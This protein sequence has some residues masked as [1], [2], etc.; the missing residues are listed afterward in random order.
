MPKGILKLLSYA[1]GDFVKK[2]KIIPSSIVKL[3]GISCCSWMAWTSI[4]AYSEQITIDSNIL[5]TFESVNRNKK[6]PLEIVFNKDFIDF[7]TPNK[8]T[9][10]T[11]STIV[12]Q[13]PLTF[14]G[15]Q[16]T[17]RFGTTDLHKS[18]F[19]IEMDER[20]D[21]CI[22]KNIGS[23]EG[24][25]NLTKG[26]F[27]VPVGTIKGVI[28]NNGELVL[29][30][31]NGQVVDERVKGS[32]S[33]KIQG[34]GTIKLQTAEPITGGVIFNGE[35]SKSASLVVNTTTAPQGYL[36]V[37][38]EKDWI[39]FDQDF[40]GTYAGTLSGE[41]GLAKMG[42]GALTLIGNNKNRNALTHI[43]SGKISI[44]SPENL[45]SQGVISFK[46]G[47]LHVTDSLEIKNPL[48]GDV[49][50][51][52][53][54]EKTA[55][56]S[57]FIG[58]AQT[59]ETSFSVEGGGTI[60]LK[61]SNGYQ[62]D[63]SISGSELQIESE[64]NLGKGKLILKDA[65]LK[66]VPGSRN[67]DVTR[68]IVLGKSCTI[69]LGKS[70]TIDISDKDTIASIFGDIHAIN[71]EQ[72]S[73][74]K[75][76][77]GKLTIHGNLYHSSL[78]LKQGTLC[79][80]SSP[81][82]KEE[83]V[84]KAEESLQAI[85][86]KIHA[87]KEKNLFLKESPMK[88]LNDVSID[89]KAILEVNANL[90]HM[91]HLSGN[92]KIILD[93]DSEYV[94]IESG[95]FSGSISNVKA[96]KQTFAKTSK[97][98]L[99]LGGDA[100]KLFTNLLIYEGKVNANCKLD[101]H[102]SVM[103]DS[104]FG[105]NAFVKYLVNEGK[106]V[107]GNSIGTLSV[108]ND[109]IQHSSGCLEIEVNS[110]GRSDLIQVGNKASLAGQLR[111]IPEP[112]IYR[113]GTEYPILKAKEVDGTFTS[114]ENVGVDIAL[115]GVGYMPN[116]VML[117][118]TETMYQLP[119]DNKMSENSKNLMGLMQKVQFKEGTDAFKM[120]E[121][122]FMIGNLKDIE[123]AY[124]QMM[125]VQLRGMT[126]ESYINACSVANSF[127]NALRR[128]DRCINSAST[129]WVEPI[130]HYAHQKNGYGLQNYHSYMGGCIIGGNHFAKENIVIG[131]GI[132]YTDSCLK[133]DKKAALSHIASF[134]A[135]L[136]G[137]WMGDL[138]YANASIIT[139][140]NIFKNKRYLNFAKVNHTIKSEHYGIGLTS[141]ME[142]G[143]NFV[144][145]QNI[146]LR[147]FVDLDLYTIFERPVQ[148]KKS[149]PI[150]F[151][152]AAL[153][154]HELRS[155]VALE[156][157]GNFTCNS[158]CLSPG[159]LLGWIT[160][161]PIGKA[162]YSVSLNN[163]GKRLSVKEFKK[164][165]VHQLMAVGA[166]VVASYKTTDVSLYYEFDFAKDRSFIHQASASIDWKF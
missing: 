156:A 111:I 67:L 34:E 3:L 92:G 125:P 23:I 64:A 99:K 38:R 131:A 63:T 122:I 91:N 21:A 70:C 37:F 97:K 8:D 11:Q 76:G 89:S 71:S 117:S 45:G 25:V 27:S 35:G 52:I 44:Q 155:K 153:T 128:N 41:G 93:T 30:A 144:I 24:D 59:S 16:K 109:F 116:E 105:G 5:Q 56:I 120:I 149:A 7:S 17:I 50:L 112:G 94:I 87:C 136:N 42:K 48:I 165:K 79:I 154:S 85:F 151:R 150:H 138:F 124:S 107:P 36:V 126:H 137:G 29:V 49:Y 108:E 58:N 96:T 104:V 100:S 163:T 65:T 118:V 159:M 152:R 74:T 77:L 33:I 157:T 90:I 139:S 53:D 57:S 86:H 13:K 95:D 39:A 103:K 160:Q 51:I 121:N 133:W 130:G 15:S 20:T 1:Q 164:H 72:A 135:G 60:H 26:I 113:K 4:H 141:R 55:E 127:T 9:A 62:G 75:D 69:D 68:N 119:K 18:L 84:F 114:V 102:V 40:N 101:T 115:F 80:S 142:A 82:I 98:E 6:T 143:G 134:Y 73:L 83:S 66:T 132:G 19:K 31:S 148:E 129:I 14:D 28:E 46:G 146:C 43:F 110:Q 2:I 81:E 10:T 12:I 106:V 54:K 145:T 78:A 162:D 32:G 47:A 147:P 22:F 140:T 158:I 123:K 61:N 88:C 161:T 166:N